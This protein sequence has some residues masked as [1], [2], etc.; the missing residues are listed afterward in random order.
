MKSERKLPQPIPE[1]P[2]PIDWHEAASLYVDE[3]LSYAEVA[4][5]MGRT[6]DAVR[7][8][9]LAHGVPPRR[10]RPMKHRKW[11]ERLYAIWQD[12]KKRCLRP[13]AKSYR[14]YGAKGVGYC[15]EW[16]AF[17]PFYSWA[18][19]A[20]YEPGRSLVLVDGAKVF[21]PETCDW[22]SPSD[23]VRRRLEMAPPRARRVVTALGERKGVAAWARDPR[24]RVDFAILYR[25]IH[26]GWPPEEA[27]TLPRE[28]GASAPAGRHRRAPPAK[29]KHRWGKVNAA[30]AARLH[31][32]E[33]LTPARIARVLGCTVSGVRARLQR[34]GIYRPQKRKRPA[35]RKGKALYRLWYEL[36][37]PSGRKKRARARLLPDGRRGVLVAKEWER[38]ESFYSWALES[39]YRRGLCLTRVDPETEYSPRNCR[40]S[41]PSAVVHRRPPDKPRPP[42]WTVTAFGE[43]KGP[44]AWS[45]D[46]R[47]AVRLYSLIRRLRSGMEPEEA[48]TRL[49]AHPGNVEP[50]VLLTAFGMTKS[51]TD[52]SRHRRCRVT[53]VTISH[54]LRH[55][56]A[57]E[58]AIATP[59]Y[60]LEVDLK[61]AKRPRRS[62]TKRRIEAR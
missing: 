45:K 33:G 12:M 39:G 48:I 6:R 17:E 10:P 4:R 62:E 55:G 23:K 19:E 43:T 51:L 42:R 41:T 37:N 59:A 56:V 15:A 8:V 3:G 16:E 38:F 50:K 22:A 40:W 61:R 54:R 36:W 44:T 29:G 9:L 24:C 26:A 13:E 34:M 14:N 28:A 1:P 18:L 57:P 11:A 21:S 35:S 47:C 53:M 58:T 2:G 20:G 5:R 60:R 27:I 30:E 46:P 31:T 52:W 7:R 32:E 49:P 25:R